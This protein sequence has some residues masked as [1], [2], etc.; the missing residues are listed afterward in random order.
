MQDKVRISRKRENTRKYQNKWELKDIITELKNS[1]EAFNR[2]LD[3][4]EEKN[5]R[6][7]DSGI[8]LIKGTKRKQNED[9]LR[10]YG[11]I[12]SRLIF[13]F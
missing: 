4:V 13:T 11:K 6:I 7:E 10:T 9:S 2:R 3:D 5:Q 1:V 8:H 12:S